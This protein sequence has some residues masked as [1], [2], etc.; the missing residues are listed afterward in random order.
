MTAAGLAVEG[1][2]KRF[3]GAPAA[4]L[5]G[6]S[7]EVAPGEIFALLGPSGSGKTTLLRIIAGFESADAGRVTIGDR[8]VEGDGRRE[9]PERRDVG[10][11]FQQGAL[12]PHLTVARN[13]AFGLRHL[14]PDA[15][16]R[17]INEVVKL[18]GLAGLEARYP[19]ELSGGEQQ[20]AALARALARGADL[21]LLDEPLSSVD[22]PLRAGLG[23]QLRAILKLAGAT[24]ILVTHSRDEAFTLADRI[25]VLGHGVLLQAGAPET[26]Y[27]TPDSDAV[28]RFLG[29][30]NALAGRVDEGEIVTPIGRFPA[31]PEWTA[32]HEVQVLVRP[33]DCVLE[34]DADG[35]ATVEARTFRGATCAYQVRLDGGQTLRCDG[36]ASSAWLEPG[37]RVRIRVAA[38]RLMVF[39]APDPGAA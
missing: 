13:L 11:V 4:V 22:A 18:C 25:G 39:P 34:P 36:P 8:V 38:H 29:A 10:F 37:T 19:H 7:L 27:R 17:R 15:R 3:P 1:L 14:P 16:E 30:A 6:L 32:G 26:V 33:E 21:I 28:A 24:A 31:A 5:D 2:V 20:R 23:R 12:F 9:P 35:G